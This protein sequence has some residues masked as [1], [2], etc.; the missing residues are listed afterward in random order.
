[1]AVKPLYQVVRDHL[2]KKIANGELQP[3]DLIP[4]ESQLGKDLNVSVGTVRKAVD[5]LEQERRLYR[6]QG[7]GTYVSRIDFDNSLFRFFSYGDAAGGAAS[8]PKST[9]VR[10]R[11]AGSEV[12]C[13]EL[14]VPVGTPLIYLERIGH[15]EDGKPVMV[16]KCWWLSEMVEGIQDSD[17]HIPDLLYAVVEEKFG[18]TIVR[19][20]ETLTAEA[21][22]PQ[23]AELLDIKAGD[24]VVVLRRHTFTVND[25]LIEYRVTRG[26]ADLFSYKTEIR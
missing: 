22:N 7:K 26:R 1:M 14:K 10:E 12:V 18:V 25:K 3:G 15:T 4:S 8:F 13:A 17:V 11:V 2:L 5:Q 19:S 24:P 23:N 9:P 6:H 21:V 20:E 16:E